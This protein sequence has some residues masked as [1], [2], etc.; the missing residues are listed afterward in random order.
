[1]R[2]CQQLH[3][4]AVRDIVS[5]AEGTAETIKDI[6]DVIDKGADATK[7]WL[8]DSSYKSG[9]IMKRTSDLVLVF[10]VLVST[11]LKMTTAVLVSKAIERKCVSLLQILFSAVNLTK[12]KDTE[13]FYDYINRFHK[14]LNMKSGISLDD[15]IN[16]MDSMTN[17]G[18]IEVFNKDTYN[19]VMECMRDINTAAKTAMRE[20][21]VNDFEV[22]RTMFGNVNVTL[23]AK[24]PEEKF[25]AGYVMNPQ[26]TA[27]AIT[28]IATSAANAQTAKTMKNY[29][30]KVNS[31]LD[32]AEKQ[33]AADNKAR[34]NKIA[35]SFNSADKQMAFFKSQIL[36]SE[37]TKSNELQPTLVAVN[38]MSKD[39][40][41]DVIN[42]VGVLGVK[43][44]I[45]P[46]ESMQLIQ[47]LTEKYSDSNT[48]MNL[49]KASTK[50][51]SFLSDFV[52]AI[53]KAKI[54]AINVAKG[55]PNAKLFHTLEK[56]AR[57]SKLFSLLK[58]NDASPITTLVI[59]QEEVEYLKK[60]SNLDLEKPSV[61]SVLMNG[62]NLMG[63][64][65]IDDSI[66]VARFLWDDGEATFE[67]MTYDGL[68]KEDKDG[69]YKKII[70]LMD[71]MN[72]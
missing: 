52:F 71:R 38:F 48:L 5:Y 25:A 49:I 39:N 8:K 55:S 37:I 50:E 68:A 3:D 21:S 65:L 30:N 19:S 31:A 20:S 47:R 9:S 18:A 61:C 12:L 54:D 4:T 14:N 33:I 70:S 23:E 6:L 45:Y 36:P 34:V 24:T 28:G 44:K 15:F 69:S 2:E 46:V 62:F 67:T 41:G 56:R 43:A 27:A 35:N 1:M 64:I 26:T 32:K 17:E 10:P 57:N 13:T 60:Y 7:G 66:E 72:R 53:Q 16:V 11:S 42:R 63:V 51:K 58:R 59:S 29:T 40:N 22:I